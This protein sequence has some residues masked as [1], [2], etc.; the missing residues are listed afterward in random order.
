VIM[1]QLRL[2]EGMQN[3]WVNLNRLSRSFRNCN[4]QK[5]KDWIRKSIEWL[6]CTLLLVGCQMACQQCCWPT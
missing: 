2:S 6:T 4:S 3:R 5:Q 1:L